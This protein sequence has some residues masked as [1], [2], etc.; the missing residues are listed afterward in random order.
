MAI[1]VC[2]H[3][4]GDRVVKKR[5][6]IK[7]T[8]ADGASTTSSLD[9]D[10]THTYDNEGRMT[11][12]AYPL[13]GPQYTMSYDSM[14]RASTLTDQNSFPIAS[15][16]Y[17]IANELQSLNGQTFTYNN[18]FQL[19]RIQGNGM[20]VM[21]AYSATQNNGKITSQTDNVSGEQVVYT[22]DSLQRLASAQTAAGSPAW[23]QSYTYDGWG[24]GNR[25]RKPCQRVIDTILHSIQTDNSTGEQVVYTYDSLQRLAS[26]TASGSTPW[27]E[28]YTYDGWGN[29]TDR[30][31]PSSTVPPYHAPADWTTNRATSQT[32]DANGNT[33]VANTGDPYDIEN[34]LTLLGNGGYTPM[35]YGYASG[36][37]R[38]YKGLIQNYSDGVTPPSVTN[39]EVYFYSVSGQKIGTYK[40]T[41]D[42]SPSFQQVATNVWLGGRLVQKNGTSVGSDRLGSLGKYYPYGQEKGSGNPANGQ[43][44]FATYT[45]DAETGLDYADQRYHGPGTGRFMSPDPYRASGDASDP[46][47]WN[48]YAYTR[49]DPVGRIDPN[50]LQDCTPKTDG[51]YNCG[52]VTGTSTSG[53]G[54]GSG[55]DLGGSDGM[56]VENSGDLSS[57]GGYSDEYSVDG[58]EALRSYRVT[59]TNITLSNLAGSRTID[60]AIAGLKNAV[61]NDGKCLAWLMS[62]PL[63]SSRNL[64]SQFF[65]SAR[66]TTGV[67]DYYESGTLTGAYVGLAHV[68]QFGVPVFDVLINRN[69][70]FFKGSGN[71]QFEGSN[72]VVK[73]INAATDRARAF[74]L[75]HE[76]SHMLGLIGP[77]GT[78]SAAGGLN[79]DRIAANCGSAI[80]TF[81]NN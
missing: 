33:L 34:R 81:R 69:S 60:L 51:T 44:K 12:V 48:R 14:G 8:M 78:S 5:L 67:A 23:G 40:V 3:N 66:A 61:L 71:A 35:S 26:A 54:N 77:D 62:S 41:G 52:G 70:V 13:S 16:T 65:D 74:S 27:D 9:L 38:I 64:V 55:G 37:K 79:N 25:G 6:R 24:G 53:S 10:A 32:Y 20:D 15:A 72:S 56:Q 28:V 39:E 18:L 68:Q 57:G 2:L 29:L 75:L 63:S 50:G 42:Q 11:S 21:Y 17:G 45:R 47:S 46:A 22:Y 80:G 76:F 49:G 4:Q 58:I 1:V 31:S 19:T 59:T 30:N 7:K 73:G 43:E 36:N